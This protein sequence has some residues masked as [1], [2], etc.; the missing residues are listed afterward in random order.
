MGLHH[1]LN[2][3]GTPIDEERRKW[4]KAHNKKS[5]KPVASTSRLLAACT[6]QPSCSQCQ[7][8]LGGYVLSRVKKNDAF[9]ASCIDDVCTRDVAEELNLQIT[10]LLRL[11]SYRDNCL[12][13][14]NSLVFD[15]FVVCESIFRQCEE[16]FLSSTSS[17]KQQLVHELETKCSDMALPECHNIKRKIIR[18]FT[19]VRL[20]FFT[21]KMRTGRKENSASKK[22]CHEMSSKSM[23]M[24]KSVSKIK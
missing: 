16:S 24:R 17:I 23:Q 15:L 9:C 13:A 3:D 5:D 22:D 10:A 18:Q 6:I 8:Y 21:K 4:F 19:T 1:Q 7:Y 12:V 11:K 14:C 2:A 20:Q